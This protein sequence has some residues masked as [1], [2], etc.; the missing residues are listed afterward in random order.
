MGRIDPTRLLFSVF[1]ATGL[2]AAAGTQ[3]WAQG[4]TMCPR[5]FDQCPAHCQE[6]GG[7]GDR[8]NP[9][10]SRTIMC[11]RR[12]CISPETIDRGAAAAPVQPA[13]P[14][15]QIAPSSAARAGAPRGQPTIATPSVANKPGQS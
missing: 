9:D 14:K 10:K 2:L 1:V 3:C 7:V 11:T 8:S 15:G 13:P 4:R 5:T 12:P 6:L